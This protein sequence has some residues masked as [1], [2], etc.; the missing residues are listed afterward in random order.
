MSTERP[1]PGE[2]RFRLAL[3]K[4][5]ADGTVTDEQIIDF[6]IMLGLDAEEVIRRDKHVDERLVALAR[7]RQRLF[8]EH[9]RREQERRDGRTGG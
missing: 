3:L 9:R 7:E 2:K 5:S 1:N 4:P 6:I 8:E